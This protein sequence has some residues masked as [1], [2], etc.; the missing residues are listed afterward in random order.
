[1]ERGLSALET[2]QCLSSEC[3]LA[4]KRANELLRGFR[5]GMNLPWSTNSNDLHG[6][7]HNL[8]DLHSE[9]AR[10]A[11]SIVTPTKADPAA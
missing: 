10:M 9:V 11:A 6:L 5:A 4:A 7:A 1:M 3:R 2:A 8:P